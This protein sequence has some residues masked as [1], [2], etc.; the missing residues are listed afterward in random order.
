MSSA[1]D[2]VAVPTA[3]LQSIESM[4]TVARTLTASVRHMN[5]ALERSDAGSI[6]STEQLSPSGPAPRRERP[7]A[8]SVE[9]LDLSRA[10]CCCVGRGEGRE[11]ERHMAGFWG[12]LA[13]QLTVTCDRW[14]VYGH[15]P[16]QS[17]APF[18]VYCLLCC[19]CFFSPL[20]S[21]LAGEVLGHA[22][23]AIS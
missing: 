1:A 2:K 16:V 11:R 19:P 5:E 23:L 21:H 8:G 12:G 6:R 13:Q 9:G 3:T 7:L 20:L 4:T 14:A 10:H 18:P 22:I 15:L 17:L